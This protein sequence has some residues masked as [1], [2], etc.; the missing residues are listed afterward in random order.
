MRKEFKA[1][2]PGWGFA[3]SA[4]AAL[5]LLLTGSIVTTYGNVSSKKSRVIAAFNL[6]I[7]ATGVGKANPFS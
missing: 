6:I 7:F 5:P 3:F 2:S 4:S 1:P